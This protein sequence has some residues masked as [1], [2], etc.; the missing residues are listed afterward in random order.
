MATKKKEAPVDAPATVE[1]AEV[2]EATT[3]AAEKA[4]VAAVEAAEKVAEA[5]APAAAP[6]EAETPAAA[7]AEAETPAAAPVDTMSVS[8][9]NN[10]PRTYETYT[11]TDLPAGKTVIVQ[12]KNQRQR[13]AVIS[14]LK[15]LNALNKNNRYEFAEV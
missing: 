15:Q 1:T 7:P 14:K 9:K 5:E 12:C 2:A 13:Q 6:A 3:E 4:A 11:K 10:G 8:I